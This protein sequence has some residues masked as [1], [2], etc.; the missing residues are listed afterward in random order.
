MRMMQFRSRLFNST[1]RLRDKKTTRDVSFCFIK[2]FSYRFRSVYTA[3]VTISQVFGPAY[4]SSILKLISFWSSL[5]YLTRNSIH[6]EPSWPNAPVFTF[7]WLNALST[8]VWATALYRNSF[9]HIFWPLVK[10][11]FFLVDFC[12]WPQAHVRSSLEHINIG[13]SHLKYNFHKLNVSADRCLVN[14]VGPESAVLV[15]RR[16]QPAVQTPAA[17]QHS[18]S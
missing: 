11:V 5:V 16:S 9:S 6:Q 12:I 7:L 15:S 2:F 1:W 4:H 13:Q 10:S 3:C 18:G 17:D 8:R 14:S